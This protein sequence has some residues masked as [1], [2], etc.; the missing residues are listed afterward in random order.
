VSA[1]A[2]NATNDAW[3]AATIGRLANNEWEPPRLYRLTDGQPPEALAE[4]YPPTEP[5]RQKEEEGEPEPP[6]FVLEP[7]P[8]SPSAEPPATV[9]KSKAVK[10]PAPV[11]D[12]K[13]KLHTTTRKGHIILSLYLTFKLRRSVTIGAHALR[14]GKVVSVAKPRYFTGRSG[15]LILVLNRKHWP[16]S[17]KFVS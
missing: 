12:V 16:T 15:R 8:P 17:V 1:I 11:Y 4:T 5:K 14:H 9:T 7:P 2:A 3:A 6:T 13:A 10:L